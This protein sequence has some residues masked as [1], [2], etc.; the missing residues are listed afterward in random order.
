M[1]G[2]GYIKRKKVV[3]LIHSLTGCCIDSRYPH[4][5]SGE[6]AGTRSKSRKE[7]RKRS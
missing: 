2:S 7:D 3:T 5:A 6:V 4:S 1:L